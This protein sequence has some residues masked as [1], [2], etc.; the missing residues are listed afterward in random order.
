MIIGILG[1]MGTY[2]T[3]HAFKQYADIFSATKEWDRPRLI[4]DNRCTMPS[5]VRAFLYNEKTEELVEEMSDSINRMLDAGCDRL[6]LAC[7]TSHLFLPNIIK[8]APN[9]IGKIKN[10]IET[11]V[12][13]I[14]DDNIEEVYLLASEGTIES[15][16]YQRALKKRGIKCIAPE[17]V[18][19]EL[20]RECIESVKQNNYSDEVKRTF[21][22]LINRND[23]CILGC[24]ELPILYEKYKE[25]VECKHIFDP[26][27]L[28]L[29]ELKEEYDNG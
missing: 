12:E 3:A 14:S 1:G 11:C 20:L 13:K 29:M 22:N 7:N 19:Y 24:T 16:I 15:Q 8:R 4:V 21:L 18:E 17:A 2:A 26:I 23:A 25:Y 27:E 6:I 5:R 28:T 10:I 9:A